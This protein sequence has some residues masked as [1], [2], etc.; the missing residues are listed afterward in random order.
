MDLLIF[1]AFPI[2]TILLA[3]VLEKVLRSPVLVAVIFFAIYLIVLFSLFA[4]GAII[5]LAT[6]LIALIIFTFLAYITAVIVRFIRCICQNFLKPCCSICPERDVDDIIDNN[7]NDC[8]CNTNN[9]QTANEGITLSGNIIP[10]QNNNGRT[11]VVRGCYRR[12]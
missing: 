6:L 2:A 9:L 3:I 7:D 8:N 12:Y 4:T 5:D 1:L 11:G 10:N